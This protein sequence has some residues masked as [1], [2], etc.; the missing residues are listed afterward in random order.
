[1]ENKRNQNHNLEWI[2]DCADNSKIL[3]GIDWII[4]LYR[5]FKN[6]NIRIL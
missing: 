1:M 3:Q 4:L 2:M 6:K 5:K